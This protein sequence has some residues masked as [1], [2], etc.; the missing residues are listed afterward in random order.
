MDLLIK[1]ANWANNSLEGNNSLVYEFQTLGGPPGGTGVPD[2]K[3]HVW[4]NAFSSVEPTS[5]AFPHRNARHCL[6]FKANSDTQDGF[7]PVAVRMRNVFEKVAVYVRGQSPYYNHMDTVR[8]FPLALLARVFGMCARTPFALYAC[9][10]AYD[11]PVRRR[12][13]D[14]SRYPQPNQPTQC[15]HRSLDDPPS[16]HSTSRV[17]TNTS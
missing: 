1:E 5:T 8:V 9:I 6:M 17:S 15:P 3:G 4:P 12:L 13:R 11:V 7:G 16:P 10:H 2:S 14:I